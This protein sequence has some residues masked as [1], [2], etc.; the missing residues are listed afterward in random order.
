MPV[1]DSIEFMETNPSSSGYEKLT[2]LQNPI[3]V[4]R[5]EAII[6]K[7]PDRAWIS[8]ATET[9][10]TKADEARR[11]SADNMTTI[12]AVLKGTGL[13]V[14]A[15]KTTLYSLV[16][17]IEW[18]NGR[19]TM[20]GYIVHNRI[21]VRVDDL[22]R[23]SDVIDV[24]NSTRDTS[25]TISGLRFDLSNKQEIEVEALKQAVQVAISRAQSIASGAKRSLGDIVRIEEQNL[26]D[27]G[28][29]E[30]LLMRSVTAK[31]S[32]NFETPI[33]IGDIEVE[34]KV[35]LTVAMR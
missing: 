18:K 35:I 4:T 13:S 5:G 2:N 23:L 3:I 19:G 30:P 9:H 21:E 6:K 12:Q 28:R 27:V 1:I 29:H 20:K 32:D 25:V 8:I 17:E 22:D 16:P 14:D 11:K 15:I 24:V 33:T 7:A 10:D 34:V 31:G 26:V